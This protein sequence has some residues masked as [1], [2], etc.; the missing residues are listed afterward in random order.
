MREICYS[1][2]MECKGKMSD[3]EMNKEN[4]CN[5]IVG[6]NI[7]MGSIKVLLQYLNEG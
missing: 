7:A 1:G 3:N 6:T 4:L 5:I 2:N